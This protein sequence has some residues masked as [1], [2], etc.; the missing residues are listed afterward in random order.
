[1]AVKTVQVI[2]NGTTVNLA[3]N[4]ETG[5]YEGNVTAPSKSSYNV[6]SGH[7]YPVTVK[8]VDDAGNITTVN[9]AD[10]TLGSKLRLSAPR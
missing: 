5:L 7:Y 2:I 1:M 4:S 3:L 6:N 10:A 8:A 9:D